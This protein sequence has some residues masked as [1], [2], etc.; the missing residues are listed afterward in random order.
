MAATSGHH[1]Y[2]ATS[3]RKYGRKVALFTSFTFWLA[4]NAFI[5]KVRDTT[6]YFFDEMHVMNFIGTFRDSTWPGGQ[7][8]QPSAPRTAE[9][10]AQARDDANRM[11]SALIPGMSV[12][13][14]EIDTQV[15][16]PHR[17]RS[18]YDRSLECTQRSASHIRSPTEQEAQ[19]TPFVHHSG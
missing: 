11:L 17:S 18:K 7:F 8:R 10:K 9:E 4:Y 19:P 6:N 14:Q 1:H 13:F 15:C 5:R 12:G 2:Y 3:F 16:T